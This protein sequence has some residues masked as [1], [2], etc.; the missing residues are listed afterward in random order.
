MTGGELVITQDTEYVIREMNTD[1]T[2]EVQKHASLQIILFTNQP[3]HYRI[4]CRLAGME[5]RVH[6]NAISFLRE[7][8]STLTMQ[9]IHEHS[10]T[11]SRLESVGVIVNGDSQINGLIK[12]GENAHTSDGYEKTDTLII[13]NG[14]STTVPDLEIHNNDV[15]CS[16][17]S[18]TTKLDEEKLF[19]V[20]SRGLSESDAKRIVIKGFYMP[21]LQKIANNILREEIEQ[22][23]DDAINGMEHS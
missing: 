16:H 12:I 3:Q 17:G 21:A 20:Q 23:I 10:H 19:Y 2:F 14:T 5:S 15:K 9:A 6:V 18:S 7:G 8:T 22:K 11:Y 1:I 4:I 13:G